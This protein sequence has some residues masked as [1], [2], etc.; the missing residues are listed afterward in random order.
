MS[1]I[2]VAVLFGFVM[3]FIAVVV[4]FSVAMLFVFV[5]PERKTYFYAPILLVTFFN[6]A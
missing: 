4:M 1:V 6:L 2:L 3:V 5:H